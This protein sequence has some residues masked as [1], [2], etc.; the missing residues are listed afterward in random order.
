MQVGEG[1]SP[2]Y[3]TIVKGDVCKSEMGLAETFGVLQGE[4]DKSAGI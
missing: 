4:C 1:L 3:D 2:I